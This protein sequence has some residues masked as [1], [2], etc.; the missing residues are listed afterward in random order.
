MG[1]Q[2]ERIEFLISSDY[3]LF[4]KLERPKKITMKLC[5]ILLEKND[6]FLP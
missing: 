5:F 4:G 2:T 6:E 3:Y 1:R